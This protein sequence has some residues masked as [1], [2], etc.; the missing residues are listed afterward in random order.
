MESRRSGYNRSS[1]A[2][3]SGHCILSEN[4]KMIHNSASNIQDVTKKGGHRVCEE[5]RAAAS[6]I[7]AWSLAPSRFKDT[8][9]SSKQSVK[10]QVKVVDDRGEEVDK[11]E[12]AD[13]I[14]KSEKLQQSEL[15]KSEE[16]PQQ[17]RQSVRQVRGRKEKSVT[18]VVNTMIKSPSSIPKT[19]KTTKTST[20]NNQSIRNPHQSN[21]SG[22]QGVELKLPS[23]KSQLKGLK[24]ST[25]AMPR[26]I[27][28]RE[29]RRRS[30]SNHN[31]EERGYDHEER[32]LV[33]KSS[34][35]S[36]NSR[37]RSVQ[38]EVGETRRRGSTQLTQLSKVTPS[39]SSTHH[40]S[41][42]Q[43]DVQP[44]YKERSPRKSNEQMVS[45][46]PLLVTTSSTLSNSKS[47]MI[48]LLEENERART[49]RSDAMRLAA[50]KRAQ[51]L[52]QLVDN[53][54]NTHSIQQT[55]HFPK[56]NI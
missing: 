28:R 8:A 25:D 35:N 41:L 13:R 55:T 6:T 1:S 10:V 56:V 14:D 44:Q 33:S 32:G 31:I 45:K 38:E 4:S 11:G 42:G 23:P 17:R 7:S 24:E 26:S 18:R 54:P 39:F 36:A 5:G 51:Q 20:C 9:V 37:Y 43:L 29:G 52:K 19:T 50:Y 53:D 16:K 47:S 21:M 2:P 27:K 30:M 46:N 40:T 15:K 12:K 22:N 34:P 3:E 49:M 48:T